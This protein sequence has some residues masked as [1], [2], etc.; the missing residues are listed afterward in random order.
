MSQ[1]KSKN[2]RIQ[3]LEN[4]LKVIHTWANCDEY[5]SETR[6]KAMSDI[7]EKAK[8]AILNPINK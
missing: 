1:D 2:K 7:A 4:A 5:S 6:S 3:E 8:E